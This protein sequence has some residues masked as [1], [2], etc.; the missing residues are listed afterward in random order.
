MQQQT[1][2]YVLSILGTLHAK[3]GEVLQTAQVGSYK[4]S[5]CSTGLHSCTEEVESESGRYKPSRSVTRLMELAM[6]LHNC[7]L[8]V[9]ESA[10]FHKDMQ[11]HAG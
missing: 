2:Y 4:N 6:L 5:R 1:K 11:Q 10:A 9:A 8:H 7:L 3:L